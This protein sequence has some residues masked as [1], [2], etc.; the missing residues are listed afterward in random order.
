MPW[1]KEVQDDID[2]RKEIAH[3]VD[4]TMRHHQLDDPK[5]Q[6]VLTD[7]F[8]EVNRISVKIARDQQH[9]NEYIHKRWY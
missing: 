8:E 2:Y 7:L 9:A 1:R 4:K 3:I 6:N 5:L